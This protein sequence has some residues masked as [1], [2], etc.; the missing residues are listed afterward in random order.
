MKN[1]RH[2]TNKK[3][4]TMIEMIAVMVVVAV[5]L[6]AVLPSLIGAINN[7][8]VSSAAGTIRSLQTAAAN[9]Y[10]ANGGSYTGLSIATLASG[11]YLPAGITGTDSWNGTITLA[12]DA[13]AS[14]FDITLTNVP[15]AQ[16]TALTTQVANLVQATPTYTAASQT[17]KAA[18]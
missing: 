11:N 1:M 3:G 8:R 18:F 17:W 12:P 2:K 9:Y 14:W 4:F 16:A 13:N 6:S 5:I 7:S 15:T 10:N